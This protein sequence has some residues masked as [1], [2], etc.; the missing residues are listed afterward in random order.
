MFDITG[1]NPISLRKEMKWVV[2]SVCAY[3]TVAICSG[4]IPTVT[5]LSQKNKLLPPVIL[6][7]LLVHFYRNGV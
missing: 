4:K 7:W 5:K 6:G 3:E 2:A 1:P